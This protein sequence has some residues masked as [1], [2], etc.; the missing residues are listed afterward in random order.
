V[1][2]ALYR[3]TQLADEILEKLRQ[4]FPREIS[5]TVLGWAVKV[6]EAQSHGQTIF[7]YAP[8]SSG[9][10]MLAA[11]ADELLSRDPRLLATSSGSR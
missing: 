7:E 1:V 9:A 2:P 11:L 6:D 8:H 10:R 3:K 5:R 4:R